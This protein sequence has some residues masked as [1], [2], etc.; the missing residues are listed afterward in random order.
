MAQAR[1]LPASPRT[2]PAKRRVS[3]VTTLLA[4]LTVLVWLAAFALIGGVFAY[5]Y[6]SAG[7]IMPGVS[8]RGI[9]LSGLTLAEASQRLAVAF[10]PYPLAPIVVRYGDQSW[11]LTAED[12]GV[13]FDAHSAAEAAYR[14]GRRPVTWPPFRSL[15]EFS[16]PALLTSLTQLQANLQEQLATYRFGHE[17]LAQETVDR[18]AGLVWL[19]ARAREIDRPVVEASLR[20]DG[21]K[22]VTGRSQVGRSV[23]VAATLAAMYDAL[24]NN[25]GGVVEMVVK[26]TPPLLADVSQ[27]EAFVRLAFAGP[28]TL[29]APD[30]DLDTGAPPPS[31]TLSLDDLQ[32]LVGLQVLPQI[33][34][35][36]EMKAVLDVEPLRSRVGTWAAELTREPRDAR[37]DF[38]PK[39]GQVSV[40]TPSQIGRALD[41]EATLAAIYQA[42]L[43][44]E[45]TAELP[46]RLIEPAVNMHRI[47]EMGI[48]E[49]VAKGT[50]VF[51]GSS[52]DRVH[53]IVTGAAAVDGTVIPPDGVFSFNAAVGSVDAE[54]GYKDSLIIWGDRTAVGIGGGIC[55]VS[56]TLFR[57]AYL[58]GLPIVERYNHGYVV[59]W[60]G[61]PGLDATI[62]TPTVDF[63]F[64]NNTGHHLLVKSAVDQA[65]GTLTFY[66][67]GTNPG[68]TV[69]VTGPEISNVVEPGP[70]VYQQDPSLAPGQIKQVEWS[71]KGMDVIWRRVI[72]DAQGQEISRDVL[73]SSYSPWS[74][75]YLVGPGTPAGGTN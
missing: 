22:V 70:P 10:D 27:A 13:N 49:L 54:N 23:D 32:P 57:A 69:E 50:T 75:Y 38:D 4:L 31:Y 53:N 12:L 59:G 9:D 16:L 42:A 43:S 33:D 41:V 25:T 45:R 62:Y 14:V 56:T 34:G 2:V 65:K 26:D 36:L 46:L 55:Q 60:Y 52:A 37:L 72:K 64:R 8:V 28:I 61:Q 21:T 1:S 68:W 18:T 20:L 35:S 24:L 67:Y 19:A 73:Q 3:F 30:P 66:L 17:V 51:K 47:D 40:V 5:Q 6:Q 39:T 29:T 48:K 11:T 71:N 58:G 74:A 15:K 63:K 44:P 7:R